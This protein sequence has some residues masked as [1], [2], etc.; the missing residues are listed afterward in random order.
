MIFKTHNLAARI[1]SHFASL[2]HSKLSAPKWSEAM[3]DYT[4][5]L[6]WPELLKLFSS[7]LAF[8][9]FYDILSESLLI[10]QSNFLQKCIFTAK[11]KQTLSDANK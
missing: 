6:M 1:V 10:L 2:F 11:R 3:I 4:G 8:M 7:Y 9:D 5:W